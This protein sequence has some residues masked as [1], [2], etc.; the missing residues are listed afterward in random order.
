MTT[1]EIHP[2]FVRSFVRSSVV[3][4]RS[5][6][7]QMQPRF[8]LGLALFLPLFLGSVGGA[9]ADCKVVIAATAIGHFILCH[10]IYDHGSAAR[11]EKSGEGKQETIETRERERGQTR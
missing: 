5:T 4:A 7:R 10:S 2:S 9:A 11:E 8:H 3:Q 1:P 6:V